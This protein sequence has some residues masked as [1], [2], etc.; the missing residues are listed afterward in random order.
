MT[1]AEL[2]QKN[3]GIF[4]KINDW[5]NRRELGGRDRN[6][7][8]ARA[9]GVVPAAGIGATIGSGATVAAAAPIVVGATVVAA[10]GYAA[11]KLHLDKAIVSAA[12]KMSEKVRSVFSREASVIQHQANEIISARPEQKK[13]TDPAFDRMNQIVEAH[14]RGDKFDTQTGKPLGSNPIDTMKQNGF[15]E[16]Q[17]D[18]W[19]NRD[20][21]PDGNKQ[22]NSIEEFA[23]RGKETSGDLKSSVAKMGQNR[24]SGLKL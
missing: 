22:A 12:M 21:T 17:I 24:T 7:I 18:A 16:A 8:L 4:S 19:R 1:R 11:Y 6:G 13:E 5:A 3:R 15:S 9:A 10:A 20:K 23:A 14:N 2:V